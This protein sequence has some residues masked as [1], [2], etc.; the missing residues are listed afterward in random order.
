MFVTNEIYHG[1]KFVRSEE[2]KEIHSIAHIF[3]HAITKTEVIVLGNDD[4]NKVLMLTFKTPPA[5]NTGITHILEHS[6]LNGSKKYPVKEP[7]AELLKSSL[8]TFL[9]AMTYPDRTVYPIASRNAQDFSNLMD[10][11][12]D[13]VFNPLLTEATFLQEGWHYQIENADDELH[14]SG[15]VYNEM[16]GAFSD[17]ENILIEEMNKALYPD[18]IY[19]KSSGGNPHYIPDLDFKTFIGFHKSYY[20]PSNCRVFLYGDMEILPRLLQLNDYFKTYSYQKIDSA[21]K[22]QPRKTLP[23]HRVGSYPVSPEDDSTSKTYL[24]RSYL[25]DQPTDA[26][27]MLSMSVLSRILSGTS[28]SPFKKSVS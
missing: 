12:L 6:V 18:S 1:F 2:V 27:Y 16:I 19:S 24:L 8:Y 7:F 13:A 17:P 20:H 28:A 25:L 21:I 10:V 9:N 4:D 11:Y 22:P 3:R 5:D 23:H 15:V 26:E 14:Y